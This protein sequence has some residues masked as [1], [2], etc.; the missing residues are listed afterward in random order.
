VTIPGRCTRIEEHGGPMRQFQLKCTGVIYH[1]KFKRY[2][3]KQAHQI[4]TRENE[5]HLERFYA[6]LKEHIIAVQVEGDNLGYRACRVE[7]LL[8]ANHHGGDG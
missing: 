3:R 4:S 8:R 6:H 1:V 2:E 5:A 7:Y